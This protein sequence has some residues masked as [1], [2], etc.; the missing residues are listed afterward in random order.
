M[1]LALLGLRLERLVKLFVSGG[2]AAGSI[3][4][5][6]ILPTQNALLFSA[7]NITGTC[8]CVAGGHPLIRRTSHIFPPPPPLPSPLLVFLLLKY[9]EARQIDLQMS[10]SPPSSSPFRKVV[11]QLFQ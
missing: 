11:V 6:L 5:Y 7:K 3:N 1:V 9:A 10:C 4:V 8:N 2:L